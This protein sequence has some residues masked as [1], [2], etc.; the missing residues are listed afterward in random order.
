MSLKFTEELYVK[1]MNNNT[2]FEE[3]LICHFKNDM[4]NLINFDPDTRKFAK[5]AL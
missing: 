1:T 3:E 5:F 4:K 2:K